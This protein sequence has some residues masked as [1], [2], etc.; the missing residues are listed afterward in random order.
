MDPAY[1]QLANRFRRVHKHLRKWA[2]RTDVSCYR[3]YEKD[4]PDQPLIVDWYDGDAVVWAFARTRNDNPEAEQAWLAQVLE[5]VAA[6]LDLGPERIHLK[7]RAPQKD[8]QSGDGQYERLEQRRAVKAVRE[9][10]LL[11]EVN[12]SDYLDTGLFL[13]HRPTRALVREQ[14]AG[15]DVLNLFAYTGS[16]TCYA[17]AGDARSTTTVDLS[18]TYLDWASRNAA[19]NG[20]QPAPEHRFIKADCLA[21]LADAATASAR[22][23]LIICDPPTFSNSTSMPRPFAVEKDHPWLLSQCH[24]LLRTGGVCY[25]STNFRGFEFAA[26]LPAFTIED[27]TTRSIPED[28]RNKRIHRCWRMV[29]T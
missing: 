19:L 7:R 29:R 23:D 17:R 27:L 2:K 11:F 4:I 13:D 26:D 3:I 10:G 15:R 25:F 16:F 14:A 1:E 28:F 12:L 9:Q 5:A 21:W 18:N 24:A 6:G 20:Q 8:R 22:Y